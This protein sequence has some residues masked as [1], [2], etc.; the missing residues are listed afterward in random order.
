MS[1]AE[2]ESRMRGWLASEYR[3]AIFEVASE[4][5]AYALYRMEN[6]GLHVRQFF[7]ARGHRRKGLGR[8]ALTLFCGKLVPD[9]ATL[10]LD[11]LAHNHNGLAFWRALGFREY[12]VSFRL[13][14][15][16]P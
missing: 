11:V 8:R 14:P 6:D 9:G 10:S 12:K 16:Q 1:V 4:P 13:A 3:A 7:V 2:L 15:S 5:V